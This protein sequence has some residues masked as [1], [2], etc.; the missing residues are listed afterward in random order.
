MSESTTGDPTCTCR[1]SVTAG[2]THCPIH[3]PSAAT[4]DVWLHEYYNEGYKNKPPTEEQAP[5]RYCVTT[6]DGNCISEDPRCMHQAGEEQAEPVAIKQWRN[7]SNDMRWM[8]S[9]ADDRDWASM[10]GAVRY[11]T[12]IVF[13]HP[14]APSDGLRE[15]VLETA[16]TAL[17]KGKTDN[18]LLERYRGALDRIS[19]HDVEEPAQLAHDTLHFKENTK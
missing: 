11:E 5:D 18:S 6:A 10:Q 1:D 2:K 8:D 4:E 16:R 13:T 14:P 7:P 19:S 15:E 12:R 9:I 3:Q 17:N